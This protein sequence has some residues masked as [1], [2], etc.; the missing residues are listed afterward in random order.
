MGKVTE[1]RKANGEVMRIIDGE[2][3]IGANSGCFANPSPCR[4]IIK[5]EYLVECERCSGKIYENRYEILLSRSEL[6]VGETMPDFEFLFEFE[7]LLK[8]GVLVSFFYG[9]SSP[10]YYQTEASG[11]RIFYQDGV[12]YIR[13]NYFMD[14]HMFKVI[15][16]VEGKI[17]VTQKNGVLKIINNGNLIFQENVRMSFKSF[18]NGDFVIGCSDYADGSSHN[19]SDCSNFCLKKLECNILDKIIIK[20]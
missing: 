5:G 2:Y 18:D 13:F 3:V 14:K 6:P 9:S 19:Y 1:I 10:K 4:K 11:F 17:E 16:I 8:I 20:P 12:L 15:P 7:P